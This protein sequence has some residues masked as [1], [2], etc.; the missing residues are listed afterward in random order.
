MFRRCPQIPLGERELLLAVAFVV[1]AGLA[2]VHGQCPPPARFSATEPPARQVDID[3]TII[4]VGHELAGRLK[5]EAGIDCSGL[6]SCDDPSEQPHVAF[7]SAGE[8][9]R[10]LEWV[11]GDVISNVMQPP[12]FTVTPGKTGT[13]QVFDP[14][15]FVTGVEVTNVS[16]Q[17][18]V[19]P[20]TEQVRQG[21]DITV[22]PTISADG[23]LVRVELNYLDTHL[24]PTAVAMQP[25]STLVRPIAASGAPTEPVEFTQYI[26][27]P[28]I[29]TWKVK[30]TIQIPNGGTAVLSGW[31][32]MVDRTST[33]P[34][35]L[36]GDLPYIGELF[37]TRTKKCEPFHKLLLVTPH[38]VTDCE[39]RRPQPAPPVPCPIKPVRYEV[40]VNSVETQASG[41]MM[42][43]ATV[44]SVLPRQAPGD[45]FM[46]DVDREM[47]RLLARKYQEA[48]KNGFF[49]EARRLAEQAIHLDP[50]CFQN[51]P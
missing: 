6:R 21:W 29:N 47:A 49:E 30:Q 15:T 7:L 17:P 24:A 46:K 26:Q 36:L 28:Q 20:K 45:L 39:A 8:V 4:D 34:V 2:S 22:K 11:Q 37:T 25:V 19:V 32:T 41:F 51:A 9:R 50:G 14:Q 27:K 35:P 44:P 18:I 33:V 16:G 38:I 5:R 42:A 31:T 13:F 1:L 12:R 48:C 23:K 3:L 43:T 10:L 40:P